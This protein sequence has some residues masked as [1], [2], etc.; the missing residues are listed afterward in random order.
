MERNKEFEEFKNEFYN[1]TAPKDMF[2]SVNENNENIILEITDE[3]L[4]TSTPQNNGWIRVN[5]YHKDH[6]VEEY[7][8]K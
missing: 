5:V 3:Y 2:T 7:Y 6:T 4:K 8:D 1:G